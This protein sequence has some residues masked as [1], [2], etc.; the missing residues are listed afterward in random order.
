[1]VS[2]ESH[3]IMFLFRFFQKIFSAFILDNYETIIIFGNPK[4]K[5]VRAKIDTGADRSSLD[6]KVAEELGLLESFNIIGEKSYKSGL[7]QQKRDVIL[8]TFKLK[9]KIIRSQVSVADRS[10]L[11]YPMLIGRADMKDFLVKPEI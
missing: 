11:V 3:K 8:V 2:R 7:G 6:R 5:V 4:Q 9:G 10:H 1:M